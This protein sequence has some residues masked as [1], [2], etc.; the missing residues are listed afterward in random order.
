MSHIQYSTLTFDSENDPVF[1]SMPDAGE[2]IDFT[3]HN[4]PHV[5]RVEFYLH[6]NRDQRFQPKRN[7]SPQEI[8]ID[9]VY[10]IDDGGD[11]TKVPFHIWQ[12]GQHGTCESALI[13]AI[14]IELADKYDDWDGGA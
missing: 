14:V 1:P 6:N 4:A 11:E 3:D 9:E 13:D 12:D 10:R 8:E 5:Y 7:V 2:N